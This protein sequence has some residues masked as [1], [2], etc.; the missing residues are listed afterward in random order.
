M[1]KAYLL[2]ENPSRENNYRGEKSHPLELADINSQAHFPDHIHVSEEETPK[3][4]GVSFKMNFPHHN[5]NLVYVIDWML[6]LRGAVTNL[7]KHWEF[8][9]PKVGIN[10]ANSFGAVKLAKHWERKLD[11][12]STIH[13]M[14]CAE[15]YSK[16]NKSA[17]GHVMI[18]AYKIDSEIL[19]ID[20]ANAILE[21][22]YLYGL[23][24]INKLVIH[25]DQ[26]LSLKDQLLKLNLKKGSYVQLIY[27][28][29]NESQPEYL[30][31]ALHPSPE[32]VK[33][34]FEERVKDFEIY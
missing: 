12:S 28:F 19:K 31:I 32:E 16:R 2:N 10:R 11:K 27:T 7:V 21:L 13:A 24:E 20:F 15:K 4:A 33:K 23:D 5:I 6:L 30:K 8:S 3:F 17:S 26:H 14:V 9:H 29:N 25:L 18:R 1:Q 22:E 34:N